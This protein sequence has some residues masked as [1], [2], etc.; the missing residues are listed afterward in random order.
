MNVFYVGIPNP[1]SIAAP[2]A[3]EKLKINWGG[4]TA[5]SLGGGR[6]DVSV[7]NTLRDVTIIVSADVGSKTQEM[8]R[9]SFRVKTV[10]EPTVFIGANI[11]GGRQPKE[12]LLANPLITARMSPDF[13]YELRWQILSYRVTFVRSGVEDPPISVTGAQFPEQVKQRIQSAPSGTNVEFTEIRISS[14]AGT[15]NITTPLIVR[16]R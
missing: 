1:V 4:A 15:R 13:N 3:P 14:I 10:P 7:P 2:V 12:V 8:G 9:T 11:L 5:T 6:Y 16:I